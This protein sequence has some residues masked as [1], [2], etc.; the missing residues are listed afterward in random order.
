M[1]ETPG[2]SSSPSQTAPML[3]VSSLNRNVRDLLEHRIPLLWVTGE[4]SNLSMPRSGHWY[5]S[6]KDE[7]AQVRCVMFRNRSAL[8]DWQPREG[9]H[10]EAR[11]L[12]TLYEA[13]GDFQ[14]NVE[15]MRQAGQGALYEAFLRLRDRLQSEGLFAEELKRPLPR[16]PRSVGI[17]TSLQA[18]ALRD[19]LTTL[20]RRNPALPVVIYPSAVQGAEAPAQLMRALAAANR[21]REVDVLILCR[22]GGSIEDLSGFNDEALARAIRASGIPLIC[23]VGHETDFTIAD[24]VADRR[25]PTPTAAAELVSRPRAEI[26]GAIADLAGRLTRCT[27]RRLETLAQHADQLSRR[28]VHPGRRLALQRE[29]LAQLQARL[30]RAHGACMEQRRWRLQ[31]SRQR[32]GLG[33]AAALSRA[34]Q[35]L[36]A[37]SRALDHLDPRAV[38][39]RGYSIVRD[40]QGHIVRG[41]GEVQPAQALD[42][43]FASGTAKVRVDTVS[44]D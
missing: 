31:A 19:V 9:M 10:V 32:L 29:A 21:R 12:V 1:S 13:R 3:S 39:Q 22:G 14:L 27:L 7:A 36:V 2:L 43:A 28:V 38:L 25:A 15:F 41:A 6:L 18:A 5:F 11:A 42:I 16:Y 35:S 34:S 24:F 17:V 8:L 40:E 20:A 44:K 4:I 33:G 26:L 37:C 23:G 30:T